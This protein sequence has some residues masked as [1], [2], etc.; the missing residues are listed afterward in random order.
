MTVLRQGQPPPRKDAAEGTA[1]ASP[2]ARPIRARQDRQ[3]RV[4]DEEIYPLFAQR[5]GEMLL[6]AAELPPGSQILEV[7]CAVGAVTAE[8]AG[9]LDVDSRVV[10]LESAPPLLDLARARLRDR[11]DLAAR[12]FFRAHAAGARLPFAEETFDTVL[13]NGALAG[14]VDPVSGAA[15]YARVTKPGGQLL[16]ALPLR[17]TW[18]EFL[19]I[20]REVLLGMRRDE[21][22]ETLEAYVQS[23][24]EAETVAQALEAVGLQG[25][26]IDVEHWELVFRSAREFFYAPLIEQGPLS[27]WKEIAGRGPAM[28]ETFL[29]I[30][31]AIDTY[32]GSRPFTVS[33][34]AGRFAARKLPA[35]PT[36][37]DVGSDEPHE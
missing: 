29:L 36:S 17:G 4:F 5:F 28:Q 34:F 31:E 26:D 24:P 20:Y 37:P 9:R 3:A 7:G 1:F 12:V 10:A 8:I 18:N 23:I 35:L 27:R 2:P 30:K 16:A 14:V 11:P 33:V 19:D 6:A 15:D 13:V 32:F 22:L 21:T 25:V